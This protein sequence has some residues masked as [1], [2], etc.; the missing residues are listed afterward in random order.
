M[1]F[2][3]KLKLFNCDKKCTISTVVTHIIALNIPVEVLKLSF[4]GCHIL[5]LDNY[6]FPSL[7]PLPPSSPPLPSPPSPPSFS[8][9]QE[10]EKVA[11][12]ASEC[13]ESEQARCELEQKNIAL[14]ACV[15]NLTQVIAKK[16]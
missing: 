2:G 3:Q 10:F 9:Y 12:K 15:S 7:P 8:C 13:E 11:K 4:Q 6:T 16:G 14:Q 5:L 1:V